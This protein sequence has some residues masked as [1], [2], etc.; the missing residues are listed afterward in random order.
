MLS[1]EN[2]EAPTSFRVSDL[3]NYVV[4]PFKRAQYVLID[5][6]DEVYPMGDCLYNYYGSVFNCLVLTSSNRTYIYY[7]VDQLLRP[8]S[9]NILGILSRHYMDNFEGYYNDWCAIDNVF[10]GVELAEKIQFKH[11]EASINNLPIAK[12]SAAHHIHFTASEV[13]SCLTDKQKSKAKHAF[14]ITSQATTTMMGGVILWLAMLP[15]DLH[16][17]FV[18]TNILDAETMIDFAKRAK[19]LSVKAKS[20]QNIVEQ[21]LRTLFEVDVLVNRDV[22]SVDWEG[23]KHNRVEP[24]LVHLDQKKIYDAATKMFSRNDATKQRPRNMTWKDFWMARWQWSASGSVHSQ[25]TED[26]KNLPKERELRNKFIQLCQAG[27]FKAD[28]FL[29]RKQEIQ[30]WSSVKYEWGKMRAIYGTDITSYILAHYAFFNCE[31]VLPNEF[32]VGMKA[33]PSYVSAK[34]AAVLDRKTPLC[35]DFED[36]NSGHSNEAMMTVIQAYYD[37]Y[38]ERM[39]DDQKRAILWTKES[40]ANT[41]INDNMGTKT[42]YRT[43]GTLMSGWRLTTFMNSVLNYIYTQVLLTNCNENVNSVHNGDDVLLGVSN[44]DVARRTVYNAEKYN[45]RLQRSKCAFGGIAEFLRVDRVR[46]D[47][48]QYLSRNIATLMHSRV[49]SKVALNVVDIVEADEERFR[50]F[51]RRGGDEEII[52]KLRLISYKNTARIYDTELLTLYMIKSSHRV[53]GGISDLDDA[54][55][56]CIIEKDKAGKILPL[57][58]NLPGVMDYSIMLRKTLDLDVPLTEVYKRIYSATLNAVQLVRTSVQHTYNTDLRQYEVFRALYKAHAEATATP[59]FGKAMLTGFVF[60]V[61]TKS[62]NMTNLTRILRLSRDP[63]RLL[64]IVS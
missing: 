40:V 17:F 8:R 47:F 41:T 63:L 57:P 58:E 42:T 49:E 13:W 25:Y 55:V 10:A 46:G 26:I 56:D 22:G 5:A 32:P 50:E 30:A 34:V 14:R 33:R 1:L 39:D 38:S 31:D 3:G 35:V 48:G 19:I 24:N 36:F 52:S 61:L 20:M 37:V 21:D 51:V 64:R 53:V 45:I 12:I 43:N 59:L 2:N 44:F 18:K 15:D 28:H 54:P 27:T 29:N 62:T 60:D 9:R 16:A 4:V 11:N 7:K 23:E 6:L